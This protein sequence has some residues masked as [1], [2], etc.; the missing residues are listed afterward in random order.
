MENSAS[1]KSPPRR[2]HPTWWGYREAL[3]ESHIRITEGPDELIW[4]Q[5]EN[6]IYTPKDGY[7]Q[8]I[9][10]KKPD[11]LDI[12]WHNIWK[13]PAA[14]RSKLFTWCVLR[15]NI[16]TGEQL[17]HRVQHGPTWCVLCKKASESTKHLFMRCSITQN[18]WTN[19][20]NFVVTQEIGMVQIS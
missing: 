11:V 16:P 13:Y 5:A 6:G 3:I 4:N 15:N 8:L 2:W 7:N 1:V 9:S 18:L 10:H 14:P 12:W 17:M 20:K 19:F